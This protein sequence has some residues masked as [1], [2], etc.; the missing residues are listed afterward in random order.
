[1]LLNVTILLAPLTPFI[2]EFLYQNLSRALPDGSPLKAKSVHFVM[3]PEAVLECDVRTITAMARMQSIVDLGR[4]CRERKKVGSKKPLK[5]LT[6]INK[7]E[8]FIKDVQ[9]LER[10]VR[11]ELNV[12]EIK[13]EASAGDVEYTA[14][15]NF[16]LLGKRLGKE[17]KSVADGIK[18]LTQAD[19]AK[20]EASGTI[21]VCSHEITSEEMVVSRK[22]KNADNPD[23]GVNYDETSIVVMDFAKDPD[24]EMK[25]VARNVA[26]RVQ[27]LRK[28]A[29]LH[30][31]D[32]VD[33][34]VEVAGAKGNSEL[35]VVLEQKSDYIN[36]LL[37]RP[38]WS[39]G[40]LQ[41][42][43]VLVKKEE[44]EI[45]D[46]EGKLVVSLTVRGAF[47]NLAALKVLSGGNKQIE[48]G[49]KQF[50]QT[51]SPPSLPDKKVL[52]ITIDGKSYTLK[53]KEHFA[54]GPADAPWA[55]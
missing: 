19:L 18:S 20:F 5:S 43:E 41:G 10:Y 51:F 8:A 9:S 11:E 15:A 36:Q 6:V 49:L 55:Q 46:Q 31:D 29:K 33:M 39:A 24:L 44:F 21:S 16:R 52:E 37:R 7:D 47:F 22:L 1:V 34:W 14:D 54:L 30:Q 40:L 50:V 25:F 23:L 4:T 28:N 42:H 35:K 32:P 12:E 53:H 26:S 48:V 13:Y 17:M 45:P 3:I 2:T 38:L 27:M